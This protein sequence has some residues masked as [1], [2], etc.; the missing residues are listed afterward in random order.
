MP[1]AGGA[2]GEAMAFAV[3]LEDAGVVGQPVEQRAGEA[4]GTEG[5]GPFVEWQMAVLRSA[6]RL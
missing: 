6:P 5:L 1:F 4:L 2:V 3:H